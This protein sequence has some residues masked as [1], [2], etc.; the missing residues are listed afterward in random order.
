MTLKSRWLLATVLAAIAVGC[1][2]IPKLIELPFYGR[3][4]I[5]LSGVWLLAIVSTSISLGINFA[6]WAQSKESQGATA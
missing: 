2:F 6:H 5:E 1:L 3:G 4:S